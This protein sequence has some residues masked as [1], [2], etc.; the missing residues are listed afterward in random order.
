MFGLREVILCDNIN[1]NK[2]NKNPIY[3]RTHELR[4]IGSMHS[5]ENYWLAAVFPF[6]VILH[7]TCYN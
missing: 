5:G 6:V 1:N 2:D 4:K 3:C 7:T